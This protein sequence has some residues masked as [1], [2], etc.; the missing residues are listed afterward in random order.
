MTKLI[1]AETQAIYRA[2]IAR[3]LAVE[4]EFRIV[5]QCQDWSRLYSAVESFRNAVVVV[6]SSIRPQFE[7]LGD[8]AR[9]VNSKVVVILEDTEPY[10]SYISLGVAGVVYRSTTSAAFLDCIRRVVRGEPFVSPG[11]SV[12]QEDMVGTRACALLSPKELMIVALLVEGMKNKEIGERLGTSEQVIKNKL[13]SVF[14]KTGVSDRLELALFTLHHRAMATAAA[15]VGTR[16]QLQVINATH[17]RRSQV[18]DTVVASFS[19]LDLHP[20][21]V[22]A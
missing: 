12:Q 8:R 3:V 22:L 17:A 19:N 14:D 13:R 21:R 7:E 1:I 15:E 9:A 20:E 6:A 2:G 5:A 10:A 11:S 16:L 4:E 18:S